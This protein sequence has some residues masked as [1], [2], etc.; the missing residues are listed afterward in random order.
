MRLSRKSDYALRAVRHISNLP[1]GKLGSINSISEA[2]SVPREFLAKILKDLTRSGI[3]VSYQGVTGGY[4]LAHNPK[5]VSF[6]DVIEAIDGPLHLNL[7]T[8]TKTCTCEQ[9]NACQLRGFWESQE[10]MFK[11]ALQ[12]QNF[13]KYRRKT[14]PAARVRV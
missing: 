2:E 9:F 6:L 3:L 12:K 14:R 7:C 10:K 8:E 1:P 5:D 11:K 4:R 13:A